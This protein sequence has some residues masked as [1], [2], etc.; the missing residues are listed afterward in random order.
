[1]FYEHVLEKAPETSTGAY[2]GRNLC[3]K[4]ASA[5]DFGASKILKS[6]ARQLH[7][8]AGRVGR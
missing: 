2:V 7:P 5:P 6:S 8:K 4:K 3:A 1:M